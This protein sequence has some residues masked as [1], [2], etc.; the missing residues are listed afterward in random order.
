MQH[1]SNSF[2]RSLCAVGSLLLAALT[3]SCADESAIGNDLPVTTDKVGITYID[4]FTVRTS[5]VQLDSIPSSTSSTLMVGRYVDSRLGTVE[6]RGFTQLGLGNNPIPSTTT[7][8][9]SLVLTLRTDTYR[10]GDTTRTQHLLVQRLQEDFVNKTYYTLDALRYDATPLGQVGATQAQEY[11]FR[12]R[13]GARTLRIRLND[14]LGRELYQLARSGALTSDTDLQTR[15]KGLVLSPGASDDAA[16]LRYLVNDASSSLSLYYHEAAAA[17]DPIVYAFP[18]TTGS[19]HFYRLR[20]NRS[21]TLLAPLTR[22][23]QALSSNVT[24][25]ET[26]VQAGLGLYTRVDVPY[27]NNLKELGGS[28]A[29]IS[30]ELTME[31]V[32]G[33]ESRY[34]APPNTLAITLTDP[35]NRRG[36]A[37]TLLDGRT[38]ITGTY[39]PPPPA[40][41]VIISPRTGLEVISYTFQLTTYLQAVLNRSITNT[42]ILLNPTS[43]D[44]VSRVV[45]GA[46]NSSSNPLRF[47]VY[48]ARVQ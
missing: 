28:L 36:A 12:A 29:I 42:G 27:I 26:Y 18:L 20:A 21:A 38:T 17:S 35:S 14:N 10:Y 24:A 44:E 11:T 22:P 8:Y 33:T 7:S 2:F 23:Y 46:Q 40:N 48:Y 34:L 45:L 13:P 25:A 4:T 30:A 43:V 32:Q 47:R 6:A 16:L 19:R 37:V 3:T 31:G 9:D 39:P 5:T 15:F 41:P 1:N